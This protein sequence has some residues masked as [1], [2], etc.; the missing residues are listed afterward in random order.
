MKFLITAFLCA[1]GEIL[2]NDFD[3]DGDHEAWSCFR[4]F[5]TYRLCKAFEGFDD[6]VMAMRMI[7]WR[8]WRS[9][10]FSHVFV[11]FLCTGRPWCD[12]IREMLMMGLWWCSHVV[13]VQLLGR[14]CKY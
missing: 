2:H 3:G 5:L 13:F 1:C 8:T 14:F 11:W 10:D 6:S 12:G 7:S 9:G 4:V